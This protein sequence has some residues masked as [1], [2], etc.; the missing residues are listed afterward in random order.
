MLDEKTG[1]LFAGDLVFHRH[2]PSLDGSLP[3]WRAVLDR[4]DALEPARVVPGHGDA[5][6]PWPEGGAALRRYLEVLARD[7]RAAID[8]GERLGDAV[9]EIAASE[10]GRW[11]LFDIFNPANATVA[12]TE[13]EWE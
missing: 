12:Y 7:T 9:R 6:L 10:A 1:T 2:T 5:S 4:I 11:E 8:A 3:G 13:L